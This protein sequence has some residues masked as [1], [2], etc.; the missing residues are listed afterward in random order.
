MNSW[1]FANWIVFSSE[2]VHFF[3][4]GRGN[5]RF[6]LSR[7][8]TAALPISPFPIYWDLL[9][10]IWNL[11]RIKSF[12]NIGVHETS[13]LPQNQKPELYFRNR[14]ISTQKRTRDKYIFPNWPHWFHCRL[15]FC[16]VYAGNATFSHSLSMMPH[17]WF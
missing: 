9:F 8:I 12:R 10:S 1:N 11:I 4:F 13:C 16:Q 2:K 14:Q 17:F 5:S 15:H 6:S 7:S 3:H